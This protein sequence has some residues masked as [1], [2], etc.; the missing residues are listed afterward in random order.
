MRGES[1]RAEGYGSDSGMNGPAF[2]LV[3]LVT[4]SL[5]QSFEFSFRLGTVD[6]DHKVLEVP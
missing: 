4:H 1:I 5:A 2:L 3:E 6:V